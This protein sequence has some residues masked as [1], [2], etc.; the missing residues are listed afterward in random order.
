MNI[1]L[2]THLL[3]CVPTDLPVYQICLFSSVGFRFY[4]LIFHLFLSDHFDASFTA[5][6]E[7]LLV[8]SHTSVHTPKYLP[9]RQATCSFNFSEFSLLS[10]NFSSFSIGSL[11]CYASSTTNYEHLPAFSHTGVHTPKYLP[12]R[13][14]TC[15]FNAFLLPNHEDL[16]VHS[17]NGLYTKLIYWS[18][19][20]LIYS[21]LNLPFILMLLFWRIATKAF[22]YLSTTSLHADSCARSLTY[23]FIPTTAIYL[24]IHLLFYISTDLPVHHPICSKFCFFLFQQAHLP[25]NS[26]DG[27]RTHRPTYPKINPICSS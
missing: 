16:P 22:T 4:L 24:S 23:L 3:V 2:S 1:Y 11:I 17:P 18:T 15:S 8:Y 19:Y 10:V 12:V 14:A 20:T 21:K 5:K 7:H 25:A 9:V 6:Y 13:Q 27:L 26:F